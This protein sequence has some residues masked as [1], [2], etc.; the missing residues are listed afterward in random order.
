MDISDIQLVA[1]ITKEQEKWKAAIKKVE[2]QILIMLA[3]LRKARVHNSFW[4]DLAKQQ[5][6]SGI[7][8]AVSSIDVQLDAKN[9]ELLKQAYSQQVQEP[10]NV[11]PAQPGE[12]SAEIATNDSNNAEETSDSASAEETKD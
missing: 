1:E 7:N 11:E 3:S 6:L 12:Q 8:S 2:A 4:I 9:L 5:L 10:S